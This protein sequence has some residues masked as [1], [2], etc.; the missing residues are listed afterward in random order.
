MLTNRVFSEKLGIPIGKV[1]R[2]TKELLGDDP[3]ATRRSGYGREFTVNE[4][5]YVFLGGI[6][7]S[8]HGLTFG[9]ARDALEIITPWLL[10]NQLV[11][12]PPKNSGPKGVDEEIQTFTLS[13]YLMEG[14]I[15]KLF[16][17]NGT[18]HETGSVEFIE[19]PSGRIY[20]TKKELHYFYFAE[21][22][23]GKISYVKPP[24]YPEPDGKKGNAGFNLASNIINPFQTTELLEIAAEIEVNGI[25]FP[26]LISICG[27]KSHLNHPIFWK[28]P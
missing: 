7:V 13:F 18:R 14:R 2:N 21:N 11:P 12:E 24:K 5:F 15:S 27:K 8:N 28:L 19:E 4:G 26:Y 23:N 16:G 17:V 6:L 20:R 22:K 10:L 25:L 9:Q 3:K 1:R